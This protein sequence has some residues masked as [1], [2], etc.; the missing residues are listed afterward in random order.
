MTGGAGSD[1]FKFDGSTTANYDVVTDFL[2]ADDTVNFVG[3]SL[4]NHSGATTISSAI[5]AT[6]TGGAGTNISGADLVVYNI[7]AD[8]ADTA[9]EID[10]LLD[11]QAGT[12]NGGVFA[13][14][15]SDVQGNNRVSLY[16]DPDANDVGGGSAPQLVAV[17]SN[18]TSVT[19]AGAPNVAADFVSVANAADPLVFDLGAQDLSLPVSRTV[20]AST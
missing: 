3:F 5:T 18:Y 11:T 17:F 10:T 6:T 4:A 20:L 2:S 8:S 1:A 9:S 15:Y 13:L 7:A 12:F 19:A 16:Y 14:A